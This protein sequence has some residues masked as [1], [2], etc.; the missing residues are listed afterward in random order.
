MSCVPKDAVKTDWAQCVICQKNTEETLQCPAE[1]KRT[2]VGAGYKTLA[3]NIV[4]FRQLECMPLAINLE[5]LDEGN[6]IEETFL[7]QR[8]RWHKSCNVKFNSTKLRRA[9][10]RYFPEEQSPIIGKKFTRSSSGNETPSNIDK[11]FFC[12][13]CE[14]WNNPLHNASTF[15]MDTRVRKCATALH[16]QILLPK[17]SGGDPVAIEVKYHAPC[18]TSLYNRARADDPRDKDDDHTRKLEGIALAELVIFIEDSRSEEDVGPIYKLADLAD[19]YTSRLNQLLG[20]HVIGR[21][22]TTRLKDR[23][24]AMVPDLQE[25]KQG[26]DILLAFKDDVAM[27]LRRAREDCDNEAM[28]LARA[29]TIVRRDMM[30]VENNFNGSFDHDCQHNSVPKSLLSLV[31]MLLYGPNIK[32]QASN[33]NYTTQ[34]GITIAQL[35]LYNSYS[36]R[37]NEPHQYE[38][39]NRTRETPLPIYLGLSVHAKTR[40]REL[41]NNLYD[42][43]LSISYDRVMSISTDLGNGVCRRFE[44]EKVVCPTNLRKR[45]FTIAAIDNIDHNPS[46]TTAND[47]FHGTGISLFQHVSANCPGIDREIIVLHQS[48]SA[49]SSTTTTKRVSQL[50]DSFA[51]VPP[52]S[53]RHND[54]PVPEV[55]CEM[56]GDGAIYTCAVK[57][58]LLWLENVRTTIDTQQNLQ[59]GECLSWAAYH[60]SRQKEQDDTQQAISSLLPLFPDDSKSVAMIRHAVEMIRRAVTHLNPGQVPVIALDQPL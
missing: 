15:G 55:H 13:E 2:D 58:E 4:R 23:I 50:P 7:S 20:A 40:S 9:E 5:R 30:A 11:C 8:A 10:K 22:H 43:G 19:M 41:V 37:R 38:R 45:L 14:S 12:D 54:P 16:D 17:L 3:D 26:R 52:A 42:L 32:N 34:T 44:E 27:A 49:S 29:A 24:L 56:K 57:E 51:N 25:Y 46:S 28:H 1:S 53:L 36:R 21:V 18:L 60:S 39:H 48:S 47:S 59:E 35:L 33:A 6:G 31:N